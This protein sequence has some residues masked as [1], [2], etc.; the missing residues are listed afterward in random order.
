[1]A[2]K[3]E[4]DFTAIYMNAYEFHFSLTLILNLID[5]IS[6]NGLK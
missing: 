1:M 3:S 6:C 5:N 4:V 2:F